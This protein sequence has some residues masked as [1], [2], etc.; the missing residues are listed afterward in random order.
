MADSKKGI[1]NSIENDAN[2]MDVVRKVFRRTCKYTDKDGNVSYM[3]YPSKPEF[4]SEEMDDFLELEINDIPVIQEK[5]QLKHLRKLI[6]GRGV[7]KVEPCAIPEN[8]LDALFL[9]QDVQEIPRGAI[10]N[11]SI[12]TVEGK[13]FYVSTDRLNASTDIYFD[14]DGRLNFID[15]GHFSRAQIAEIDNSQ[16]SRIEISESQAYSSAEK[17]LNASS[18]S[19]NSKTIYVYASHLGNESNYSVHAIVDVYPLNRNRK[20]KFADNRL[21]GIF[22]N[23]TE[24][25]DLSRLTQYPNLKQ[26][27][28]G[29]DVKR[30][31]GVQES[32]KIK[33]NESQNKIQIKQKSSN[34]KE[35][36]V[37]FLSNETLLLT[38]LKSHQKEQDAQ[39]KENSKTLDD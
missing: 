3:G 6:L 26:I 37:E 16:K 38:Q 24:E 5:I 4:F 22:I 25:V 33:G 11:S 17:I 10:T 29:K 28:I 8:G 2:F 30:V 39:I 14:T 15:N 20:E 9:S 7:K 32:D 12:K 34:G 18:R 23:G 1:P 35:Q 13:E 36:T 27:I 31:I 19:N 21:I